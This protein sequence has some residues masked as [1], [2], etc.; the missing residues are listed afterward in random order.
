MSTNNP[1]GSEA[2]QP[3]VPQVHEAVPKKSNG[4]LL[5][6][7]I[8][9]GIAV[10]ALLVCGGILVALLLPAVQSARE[11][12]RRMQCSNNMKQIGLA[13]HNYH[14]T[15]ETLPPAYTVDANGNRLHSWRT[16]ILPFLEQQALHNQIDFSKPWD[17]PVN[18]QVM[19][20]VVPTYSCPSSATDPKLTVYQ[21]VVDPNG[22]FTGTAGITFAQIVDGIANTAM[23][24][25]VDPS[26]A[27]HWMEPNDTNL[28]AFL[29]PVTVGGTGGHP[30]GGHILKSDGAV[31]FLADSAD[32]K[33]RRSLILRNKTGVQDF[34]EGEL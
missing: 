29:N 23:V 28:Q 27:V 24:V 17:D 13:L 7:L 14:S 10:P 11:A 22:V 33:I 34:G 5:G 32:T 4:M 9:A 6:C 20:S 1:Y 15:Y 19:Q 31:Q 18:A 30:G 2:P 12:A 3:A 16:L 8:A 26:Q 25:E 21:A